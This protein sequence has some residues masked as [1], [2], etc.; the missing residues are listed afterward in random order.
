MKHS[1]TGRGWAWQLEEG[2]CHWVEPTKERLTRKDKPS[3]EAKP[4]FVRIVKE[5]DYRRLLKQAK[6]AS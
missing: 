6:G 2:L 4:V 5:A 3:P 1:K